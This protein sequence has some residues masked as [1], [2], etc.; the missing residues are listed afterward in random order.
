MREEELIFGKGQ[1]IHKK[2]GELRPLAPGFGPGFTLLETMVAVSILTVSLVGILGLIAKTLSTGGDAILRQTA[3]NLAEEGV[4]VVHNIRHTNWIA[5]RAWDTGLQDGVSCVAYQSVALIIPCPDPT[6]L[7]D[8]TSKTYNHT[9]GTASGFSRTIT[10]SH[11]TDS[12]GINFVRVL[13]RVNWES[14]S[15]V[16]E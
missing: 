7:F 5:E 14:R 1:N 3:A 6:L 15:I 2:H 9:T 4:E 11:E 13:S 12:E 10:L 8:T 16:V